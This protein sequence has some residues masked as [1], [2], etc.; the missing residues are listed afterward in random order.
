MTFFAWILMTVSLLGIATLVLSKIPDVVGKPQLKIRSVPVGHE[1]LRHYLWRKLGRLGNKIWHF[2]LEAK[3]LAPAIHIDHPMERMKQAFKIRIRSSEQDPHWLPEATTNLSDLKTSE[4]SAEALYLESI[5]RN[6]QNREAYE[7][8]GRL[9]LQDKNFEEAAEMFDFLTKF[10]PG[11]DVYWSN[12]GLSLYSLEKY[13]AAAN[14]YEKA[15]S[16][17]N[18]I[19]ARWVN[20][21][22][23]FQAQDELG[24]AIKMVNAALALDKRNLNYLGLMADFYVKAGNQV[25]AEQALEQILELDPTNKAAREKLMRLKI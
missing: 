17:N 23:C 24:K 4:K 3:D 7:G 11:R 21:A 9:Y 6:P 13:Q 16:I 14:A 8:L 2:I 22:L 20:L 18:K 10:D 12:L 15:L 25:K 1:T 5:K 19:P